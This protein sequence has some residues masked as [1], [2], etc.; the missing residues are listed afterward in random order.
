[1]HGERIGAHPETG[2]NAAL[3][4][5]GTAQRSEDPGTGNAS[6]TPPPARRSITVPANGICA[7]CLLEALGVT[8]AEVNPLYGEEIGSPR[9]YR[10]VHGQA[11]FNLQGARRL[12]CILGLE[13]DVLAEGEAPPTA[14]QPP[15][16]PRTPWWL[17]ELSED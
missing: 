9:D 12:A 15:R 16:P 7:K 1:M 11:V 5:V 2:D 14:A 8:S 10:Y 4:G 17:R 13:V 3:I 6:P